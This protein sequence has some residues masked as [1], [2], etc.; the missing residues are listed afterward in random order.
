VETA[1]CDFLKEKGGGMNLVS[2]KEITGLNALAGILAYVFLAIAIYLQFGAWLSESNLAIADYAFFHLARDVAGALIE[3]LALMCALT[4]ALLIGGL[5]SLL[6]KLPTVRA[7]VGLLMLTFGVKGLMQHVVL[8]PQG[9]ENLHSAFLFFGVW[10]LFVMAWM[11]F[12]S[13]SRK[14][15]D[16][17]HA[18]HGGQAEWLDTCRTRPNGSRQ[19]PRSIR[20]KRQSRDTSLTLLEVL[21]CVPSAATP[22]RGISKL[23][24]RSSAKRSMRQSASAMIVDTYIPR[25]MAKNLCY[26]IPSTMYKK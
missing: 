11:Y 7:F 6:M 13:E 23:S 24:V 12:K 5:L 20:N 21:M 1:I 26:L 22:L 10:P 18:R 8:P 14:T 25:C 19:S 17:I 2:L 15:L 3:A 4:I 16:G 9:Q